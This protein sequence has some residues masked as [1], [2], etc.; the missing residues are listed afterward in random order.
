KRKTGTTDTEAPALPA[1]SAAAAPVPP[2]RWGK[3]TKPANGARG[4]WQAEAW[5]MLDLVGELSFAL[6][7]KTALLSRFRLVASDLDPE[8]GKPTGSTDNE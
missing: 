5:D 8:T 4:D 1:L 2:D 3:I 6:L 7:W